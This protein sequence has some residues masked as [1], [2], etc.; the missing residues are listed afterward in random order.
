MLR[1]R[2]IE[3]LEHRLGYIPIS[4][5]LVPALP[6]HAARRRTKPFGDIS[7][8]IRRINGPLPMS[9]L[10]QD[11]RLASRSLWRRRGF[12]ALAVLTLALGIGA[13]TSI[14]S[15][16]SGVLLRPLPYDDGGRLIAVW[17]TY[18]DWKKEP[19]L[20]SMWDRIPL[21]IPEY[22]D[23]R[24]LTTVFADA[25]IWTSS[26]A[27]ITDG[28]TPELVSTLR[29]SASMLDVLRERP[30][31]GRMFRPSED[32]PAG[33]RVLLVSYESWQSRYA[34]DR[35]ILGRTVRLDDVPYVIIGVLP[36]GLTLVRGQ[37]SAANTIAFWMPVGQDSVDYDERTN[38]SYVAI[39]RL[40]PGA[41]L[42]RAR[43][44]TRRALSQGIGGA[45][46]GVRLGVW[47]NDQVRDARAPLLVLLGA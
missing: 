20:V 26:A 23:L 15:V 18:P 42:A 24:A 16:V 28:D 43:L 27:T 29:V 19:I 5:F 40:A 30:L 21:S 35:H 36:R 25:G 46:K 37:R 3:E 14:Y 9:Q 1:R 12:A 4:G 44:E 32:V 33:A 17:Q 10:V 13:T 7:R 11:L 47:Q 31:L 38:H 45:K 34:G 22:R 6:A 8:R 39:A 41:S 2:L